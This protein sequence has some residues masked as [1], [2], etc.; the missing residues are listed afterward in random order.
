V[1][2]TTGFTP[3]GDSG[4]E[5]FGGIGTSGK[6]GLW[7]TDG[8]PDGTTELAV[9]NADASGGL[10][11][12]DMTQ[13]GSNVLFNGT[14]TAGYSGLWETD[15]TPG[16][17]AMISVVGANTGIDEGPSDITELVACFATGTRI[18]TEQGDVAVEAL[19]VGDAVLT[20]SGAARAVRWIGHRR[21]DC[22][23]HPRP[24]QV[25]PVRVRAHAF[26]PGRPRRDLLLSPD[27]AVF[28]SGVL[29]PI[30]Y[31]VNG[32]SVVQENFED[33]TYWH[34]ELAGHDIVL[35]EGLPAESFLDT[36]NRSAFTNG[37]AVRVLHPDFALRAWATR[38][39]APL[40]VGGT[41]LAAVKMELLERAAALGFAI[42]DAADFCLVVDGRVLRPA[43]DG[44]TARFVLP[45]GVRSGRLVS[46]CFVPAQM[47]PDSVD[48]RRLGVA[49]AAVRLDGETVDHDDPRLTDGWHDPEPGLRWTDGDAGM[50]LAGARVL[51]VDVAMVGRYW[52]EREAA[53]ARHTSTALP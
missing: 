33:I 23:R 6:D 15:G 37:G 47:V 24:E 26:A 2:L 30:R 51:A 16:G 1:Q 43:W 7:I 12:Q 35:A 31:L 18:A 19:C 40:I 4:Q 20:L 44:A 8:T 29:I 3:V 53:A 14:D 36:G 49:V 28:A 46:K 21:V 38:A 22:R 9:A 45:S 27:H 39:C 52:A 50:V 41:L 34:V 10:A 25:W 5:L 17:T 48:H 32:A 11:P 42:T 13:F